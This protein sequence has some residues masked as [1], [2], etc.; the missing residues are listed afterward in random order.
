MIGLLSIQCQNKILFLNK[1]APCFSTGEMDGPGVL[2]RPSVHQQVRRVELRGP[3]V[4]DGHTGGRPLPWRPS[5][6]TDPPAGG[7]LQ[8]E[9]T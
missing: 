2:E 1:K 4:G 6:E 3:A 8:D 9:Q 5:R 7:W